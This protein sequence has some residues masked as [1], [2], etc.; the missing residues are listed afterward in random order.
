MK[1][2]TAICSERKLLESEGKGYALGIELTF[3]GDEPVPLSTVQL[4]RRGINAFPEFAEGFGMDASKVVPG[5]PPDRYQYR[6]Q[7]LLAHNGSL[8][9]GEATSELQVPPGKKLEFILPV[10]FKGIGYYLGAPP[11][12]LFVVVAGVK[13]DLAVEVE[14]LHQTLESSFNAHGTLGGPYKVILSIIVPQSSAPDDVNK[15][16]GTTNKKAI[17]PMP[18]N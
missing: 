1:Q 14:G 12:D 7:M 17:K 2:V 13:Q 6:T 11:E 16:I 18:N 10:P 15:H 9:Y 8:H 4:S 3:A 5:L